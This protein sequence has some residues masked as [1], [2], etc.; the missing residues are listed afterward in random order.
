MTVRLLIAIRE[1]RKL[2]NR[3]EVYSVATYLYIGCFFKFH[4]VADVEQ[5]IVNAPLV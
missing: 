4:A 2:K 3:D 5:S 1:F